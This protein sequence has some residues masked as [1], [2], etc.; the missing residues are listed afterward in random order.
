[1]CIVERARMTRDYIYPLVLQLCCCGHR[2]HR[3]ECFCGCALFELD[4]GTNVSPTVTGNPYH[5]GV[6][7][8]DGIYSGH[9]DVA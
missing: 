9:Y 1:M 7:G 6:F 4:D 8:Y 2:Q 5:S 3:V